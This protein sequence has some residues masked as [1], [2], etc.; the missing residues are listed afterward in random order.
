MVQLLRG[1]RP[2]P[3][4]LPADLIT[5]ASTGTPSAVAPLKRLKSASAVTAV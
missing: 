3:R 2:E 4:R 1:Q 5:R